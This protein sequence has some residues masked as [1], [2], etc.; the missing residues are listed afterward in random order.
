[1]KLFKSTILFLFCSLFSFQNLNA[2]F[3][4]SGL[5]LDSL[6]KETIPFA[7]IV[8]YNDKQDSI[9]SSNSS[10]LKGNFI[11]TNI[12]NGKYNLLIDF[13]GKEKL[14]ISSILINDKNI[15]LGTLF[16]KSGVQLDEVVIVS[17]KSTTE[18]KIDRKT[19][20]T[21]FALWSS[22]GYILNHLRRSK[23]RI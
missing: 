16:L 17:K 6:S 15:K 21:K 20:V 9:V 22:F 1:M 4:I 5:V 14:T 3:S 23:D 18:L 8:L 13:I 7:T 11:L 2:Q 10:D 19:R 12:P